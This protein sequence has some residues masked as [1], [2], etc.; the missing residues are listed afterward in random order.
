VKV[1]VPPP[2]APD[3]VVRA[4]VPVA[5]DNVPVQALDAVPAADDGENPYDC[6][7]IGHGA[8]PAEPVAEAIAELV[9][10]V[11]PEGT[12]E[13]AS[14][15]PLV[16]ALAAVLTLDTRTLSAFERVVAQN[17][18]I[19]VRLRVGGDADGARELAARVIAKVAMDKATL[20]TIGA[21]VG[22][23]LERWIGPRAEWTDRKGVACGDGRLLFH[24]KVYRGSRTFRPMRV[25]DTRVL[26]SQLVAIDTEGQPRVTPYVGQIEIRRGLE[27]RAPVCVV[28]IGGD[29]LRRSAPGGLQRVDEAKELH[30]TAF[31]HPLDNGHLACTTACHHGSGI[32]D[33]ADV[34]ADDA[35]PLRANRRT[36]AL[37]LAGQKLA[38]W[39][40]E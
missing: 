37:K 35:R 24:D 3:P 38:T 33:F 32:G 36:A 13:L 34:S 2:A 11:R 16:D 20:A 9:E 10:V 18:A 8:G 7:G 22:P 21:E 6:R 12:T 31:V 15:P 4:L 26:V 28:E 17:A 25:G 29:G 27:P 1:V 23:T 5:N 39:L 30:A 40:S 14:S 19:S